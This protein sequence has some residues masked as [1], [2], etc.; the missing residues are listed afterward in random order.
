M[1]VKCS[2]IFGP[3]LVDGK[4]KHGDDCRV[5]NPV[6]HASWQA[7]LAL[8]DDLPRETGG[9]SRSI[10][11]YTEDGLG[12]SAMRAIYRVGQEDGSDKTYTITV[13]VEQDVSHNDSFWGPGGVRDADNP[14]KRVVVD[15]KHYMLGDDKP[16]S[17]QFKGFGGRRFD[18]EFFDGR[19]VTTRDL[20]YQGVIP[21]KWRDLYPDNARWA[22][23]PDERQGAA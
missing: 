1:T 21:P 12:G 4:E 16:G 18:I 9:T 7:V 5:T 17:G 11:D 20:W 19:T 2:C 22:E 15:G 13:L 14:A 10:G 3:H 6:R 23:V 8:V